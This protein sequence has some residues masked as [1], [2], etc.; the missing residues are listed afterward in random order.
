MHCFHGFLALHQASD[1]CKLLGYKN[2]RSQN[3][4]SIVSLFHFHM[5]LVLNLCCASIEWYQISINLIE[6]LIVWCTGNYTQCQWCNSNVLFGETITS[7][8]KEC[9][10]WKKTHAGWRTDS[11]ALHVLVV[12]NHPNDIA[13][14]EEYISSAEVHIRFV[15]DDIMAYNS[16]CI[17]V[18]SKGNAL[19]ISHFWTMGRCMIQQNHN[20]NSNIGH[21]GD[22]MTG[23]I[24]LSSE[25]NEQ[26]S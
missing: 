15:N 24:K 11:D 1:S 22:I 12:R 3:T 8:K 2:Q 23:H 9:A 19:N 14:V 20:A 13:H 21:W 6:L 18:S 26:W 10:N 16:A 17:I 5:Y 25:M 4:E 7:T